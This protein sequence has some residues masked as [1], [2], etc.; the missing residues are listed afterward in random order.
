M[1]ITLCQYRAGN[2]GFLSKLYSSNW[3]PR[4]SGNAKIGVRTGSSLCGSR[5]A[6][7]LI[8]LMSIL[9]RLIVVGIPILQCLRNE[10]YNYAGALQNVEVICNAR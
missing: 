4:S 8:G 6:N 7:N 2:G 1:G 3:R 9:L 10:G 5:R